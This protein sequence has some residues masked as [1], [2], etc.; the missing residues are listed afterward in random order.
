MSCYTSSSSPSAQLEFSSAEL[1]STQLN[2]TRLDLNRSR[3]YC[4]RKRCFS[5]RLSCLAAPRNLLPFRRRRRKGDGEIDCVRRQNMPIKRRSLNKRPPPLVVVASDLQ[6]FSAVEC[7]AHARAADKDA[8][9]AAAPP[10]PPA[11]SANERKRNQTDAPSE[12]EAPPVAQIGRPAKKSA[13][14]QITRC[15][16]RPARQMNDGRRASQCAAAN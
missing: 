13:P 12:R 8:A 6:H 16:G 15:S 2:S 7:G 4:A 3:F 11:S 10:P 14:R 5:R 1:N 9:A